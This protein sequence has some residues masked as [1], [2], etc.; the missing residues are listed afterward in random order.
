MSTGHRIASCLVVLL[1]GWLS[2]ASAQGLDG[3][4]KKD[5]LIVP[6]YDRKLLPP[7]GPVWQDSNPYRGHAA[8]ETVNTVGRSIFNQSCARCHGPDADGSLAAPDLRLI[9]RFCQRVP[10]PELKRRCLADADHHFSASVRYG[11]VRVGI[12][13]MPPWDQ[14]LPQEAIWALRSFVESAPGGKR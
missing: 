5:D 10:E 4:A 13:H 8:A 7:V 12:T 11:K 14:T 6:Q 2:L 9:G 3:M 1:A